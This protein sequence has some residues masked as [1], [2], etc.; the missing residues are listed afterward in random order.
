MYSYKPNI[1]KNRE[2][3]I[4]GIIFPDIYNNPAINK[5]NGLNELKFEISKILGKNTNQKEINMLKSIVNSLFFLI[6]NT[7][8]HFYPP[9]KEFNLNSRINV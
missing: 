7:N 9:K 4:P 2:L 3:L 5:L 6:F 8:I 1:I